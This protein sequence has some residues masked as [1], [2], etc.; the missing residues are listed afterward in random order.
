MQTKEILLKISSPFLQLVII[1]PQ[2]VLIWFFGFLNVFFLK[3]V[4]AIISVFKKYT[5]V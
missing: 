2:G 3:V 5:V 4:L 1:L